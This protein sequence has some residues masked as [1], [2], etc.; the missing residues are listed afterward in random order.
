MDLK[1]SNVR[2]QLWS[3]ASDWRTW[4]LEKLTINTVSNF[5]KFHQ[6]GTNLQDE[7]NL[8]ILKYYERYLSLI[9]PE[10]QIL[11]VI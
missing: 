2:T 1:E 10:S 7:S 11:L 3:M 9:V 8:E 4:S 6:N 5:S